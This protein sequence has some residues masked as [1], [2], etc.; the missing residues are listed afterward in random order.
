MKTLFKLSAIVFIV[1]ILISCGSVSTATENYT[2]SPVDSLKV[3]EQYSLF[4]EYH[5]NKDYESALPYGWTIL[6]M[7]P[8]RF[9]RF[10]FY[11]MEETLWHL[12]DSSSISPEEVS[13]IQDS[14]VGFYDK[15]IKYHPDDRAYFQVRKA[16]VKE[17]WLEEHDEE[18]IQDY[19]LAFEWNPDFSSFYYHRLGQ[20]YKD[21]ASDDNDYK[22]KALD[23][24]SY[25]TEKEPDNE[26]WIGELESLAENIE[27]LV[28]LNRRAWDLD[29]E[30]LQKAWKY[31]SMAIRAKDFQTA[32]EPLE[33]LVEKS[34]DGIN[35]WNQLAAAYQKTDQL[36]NAE[37]AYRKLI[38]LEPTAKEHYLNLGFNLREQGKLS[39]ARS[40]F[41]KASEISGSWAE[42]I[43]WEGY[44]Y[45]QAARSCS[46][47]DAKVVFLLA[48]QT[49][50]KALSMDPTLDKARDRINALSDAVPTKEDYFFRNHKSGDSIN[51]TCVGWIGKSVTV[52]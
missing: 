39:A 46:G 18:V 3:L 41:I 33:F 16:Y 51:I 22:S 36:S 9:A 2:M 47:F 14:I 26:Q 11:K 8:A 30:N 52:P 1:A 20:L 27:E 28:L 6:E 12:H 43:Y 34:P 19:E 17:I 29:R 48:Q 4:S 13:A 42:P 15:A 23:L 50:R 10:F 5:K 38:E 49:Y 44:L 40:E 37:N 21:N 24:Y 35:Y 31:A 32:I 25:L 45:E 7:D